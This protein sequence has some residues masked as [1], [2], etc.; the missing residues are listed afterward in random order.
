[1]TAAWPWLVAV[2][3]AALGYAVGARWHPRRRTSAAVSWKA[4]LLVLDPEA[5]TLPQGAVRLA[6]R[7]VTP[8][9]HLHVLAPVRVP[10]AMSL[11]APAGEDTER[12]T[13]LLERAERLAGLAGVPVRGHLRRGRTLRA[14]LVEVVT[15]V[16][17]DAVVLPCRIDHLDPIRE[18]ASTVAPAQAILVPGETQE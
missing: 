12:A 1:M 7:L 2:L 5:E 18:L 8:G 14:M 15:L 9:A 3:L 10:L 6:L 17:A 4:V 11:E 16:G 13:V